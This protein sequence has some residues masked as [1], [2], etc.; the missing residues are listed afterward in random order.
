MDA[1]YPIEVG[2]EWRKVRHAFWSIQFVVVFSLQVQFLGAVTKSQP[3][4]IVTELMTGGSLLDL[5]KSKRTVNLWRALQLALDCARGMAYL[6]NRTPQAV[7][8]RDLKP[9]N[10][11]LGGPKVYTNYHKKL[12]QVVSDVDNYV[13]YLKDYN[14]RF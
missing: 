3:Y 4:M 8:H 10:I 5:F 12:L 13:L 9:A 11:M 14:L 7:V 6:H 1:H 2:S